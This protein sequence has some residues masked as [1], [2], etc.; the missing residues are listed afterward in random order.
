MTSYSFYLE[1]I[2]AHRVGALQKF[3]FP[4]FFVEFTEANTAG[5]EMFRI[6]SVD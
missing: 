4:I 1:T 3:G 6:A 5:H 2:E